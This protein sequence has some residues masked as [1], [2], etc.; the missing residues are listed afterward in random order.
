MMPANEDDPRRRKPNITRATKELGWRPVVS[1]VYVTVCVN[2]VHRVSE[3][4]YI[5]GC[6]L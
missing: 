3:C 4:T 2:C 1:P 5:E 6:D